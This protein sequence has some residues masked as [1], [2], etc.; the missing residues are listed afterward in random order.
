MS[1]FSQIIAGEQ[2]ADIVYQDDRVVAFRDINPVAPIHILVVP[3]EPIARLSEAREEHSALLGHL[4]WVAAEVARQEGL[5]SGYRVLTNDGMTAGQ[6]VDH[7]HL[8][9][10]GG[11][12]MSWPPG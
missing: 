12:W 7:L 6:T 2:P 10:I 4:L 8:H 1:I 3:R 9:V 11:A 5:D